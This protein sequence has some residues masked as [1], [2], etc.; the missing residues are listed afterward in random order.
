[1][2][3]HK[4][5]FMREQCHMS[6]AV[7]KT[8]LHRIFLATTAEN[9]P[10]INNI[11]AHNLCLGLEY[12]LHSYV[13][14]GVINYWYNITT[15]RTVDTCPEN[16]MICVAVVNANSERIC[17]LCI[18]YNQAELILV[19]RSKDITY[20]MFNL[21][22]NNFFD[23]V[24]EQVSKIMSRFLIKQQQN[25]LTRRLEVLR[26]YGYLA[27]DLIVNLECGAVSH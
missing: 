18:L 11:V 15:S 2:E 3:N 5:Q 20:G 26:D 8:K 16:N 9:A 10:T 1:M 22:D 4:R 7:T 23:K 13:E 27:N 24:Y 19:I 25:I 6:F 14:D 21:A 17:S 12:L